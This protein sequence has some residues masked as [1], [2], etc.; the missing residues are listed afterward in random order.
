MR[1]AA[2]LA[3][4]C[5]AAASA[6]APAAAADAWPSRPIRLLVGFPGGSSPDL[7]ARVLAE[8]LSHALG[9]TVIVENRPGASGNI[10]TEQIARA[11]DDH[12]LGIVINGNLTSAK[13]LTPRLPYDPERD[14]SYLAL[15]ASAPLIL[16]AQPDAPPGAVFLAAAR[17]AGNRWSYG[18]VGVGSVGHLGMELLKSRLPG[19]AAEHIP[20]QGNPQIVTALIG[21]QIEMALVAPAVA[22]PQIKAG[23]LKAIGLTSGR[24]MLVPDIAPLADFGVKDFQLEVWVALI[25]PA[26]LSNGAQAR[27]SMLLPEILERAAVRQ[28]LFDQ[29]WQ[30]PSGVSP[31]ALLARVQE[32]SR[33]MREII[34]TRN[35]RID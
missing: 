30:A 16:V 20:Y 7:A 22:L 9:K 19:L 3:L 27:L 33:V 5:A 32:E 2:W 29:G 26:S 14:F 1:G 34:T 6:S 18:S 15:I 8:H 23:R 17:S 4:S 28:Q 31:A 12:T 11:A 24:S 21:R 13:M 35:I 25:G 10:A